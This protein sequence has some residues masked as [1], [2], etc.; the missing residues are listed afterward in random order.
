[1]IDKLV[2]NSITCNRDNKCFHSVYFITSLLE[3]ME[4]RTNSFPLQN[5]QRVSFTGKHITILVLYGL[6]IVIIIMYQDVGCEEVY[7]I[8]SS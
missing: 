4:S 6:Y 7:I 3:S 1:M 2:F 8:P 5:T